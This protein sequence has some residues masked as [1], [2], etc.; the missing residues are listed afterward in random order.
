MNN[1]QV[2]FLRKALLDLDRI[3]GYVARNLHAPETA[4]HLI[5]KME[6]MVLS[7]EQMPYRGAERK[8]GVYAKKGYRQLIIDNYVAVYR[9]DETKKQV[10]VVAVKYMPSKF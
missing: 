6:D 5:D 2:K 4:L 1:Y 10:I 8:T 9:I 3:Y 7:L